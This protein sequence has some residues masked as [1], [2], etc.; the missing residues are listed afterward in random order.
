MI[1]VLIVILIISIVSG[2]AVITMSTG[3]HQQS[4]RETLQIT[5]EI[6]LAQQ[7]ALLRPATLSMTVTGNAIQFSIALQDA[8]KPGIQWFTVPGR[9]FRPTISKVH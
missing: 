6:R 3:Q 5:E 8:K 2:V 4:H 1:E 9:L 7:E